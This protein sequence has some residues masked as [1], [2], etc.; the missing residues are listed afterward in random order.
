MK[1][2]YVLVRPKQRR[3]ETV[4]CANFQDAQRLAGLDPMQVDFGTISRDE[5]GAGVGIVVYEL[6]LYEKPE[7][8]GSFACGGQLYA[9]N[10]ALFNYIAGGDSVS[11]RY[12]DDSPPITYL[13]SMTKVEQ[14]IAKQ[15]VV[16]PHM[17]VNGEMLWRWPD[18]KS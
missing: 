5:Y 2:E 16:R 14:I 8:I 1:L 10:A 12:P 6:G 9:G 15:L 4:A 3:I 18:K 11:I 13:D 7:K 17:A